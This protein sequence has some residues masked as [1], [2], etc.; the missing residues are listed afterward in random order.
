MMMAA[1]IHGKQNFGDSG[2]SQHRLFP[3]G[4]SLVAYSQRDIYVR[5]KDISLGPWLKG[6][7]MQ[8]LKDLLDARGHKHGMGGGLE[9]GETCRRQFP[10]QTQ[11]TSGEIP[12]NVPGYGVQKVKTER[13]SQRT[14]RASP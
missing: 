4:L 11:G 1:R 7:G 13:M 5:A 8:E 2:E 6:T 14:T 12:A 9:K 3:K 10:P